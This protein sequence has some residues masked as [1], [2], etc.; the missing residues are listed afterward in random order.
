VK[1]LDVCSSSTRGV[2]VGDD[3]DLVVIGLGYVGLPLAAEASRSGLAV[4]GFDVS[5]AVVNGLNSGHSHIPD[6]SPDD[7]ADMLASGFTATTRENEIGTPDVAVICVPTPLTMDDTPDLAAVM[8][9]AETV[10]RVL[11]PGALV[12]LESTTYPGTTDEVIRRSCSASVN[13]QF[14]K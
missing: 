1:E 14:W 7:I 6:V 8:S 11:R 13:G 9:A 4:I 2:R 10:G 5:D 12:V 3:P